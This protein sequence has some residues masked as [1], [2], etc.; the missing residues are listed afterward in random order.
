MG[1]CQIEVHLFKMEPLFILSAILSVG[2]H[3]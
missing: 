3:N 1:S 2:I